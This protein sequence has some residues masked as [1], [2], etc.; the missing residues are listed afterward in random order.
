M[1]YAAIHPGW[2]TRSKV[3]LRRF[4][5]RSGFAGSHGSRET[6]GRWAVPEPRQ[7]TRPSRCG[8]CLADLPPGSGAARA[9]A[10]WAWD[11]DREEQARAAGRRN[12]ER[13]PVAPQLETDRVTVTL[14]DACHTTGTRA[15]AKSDGAGCSRRIAP[16]S[17]AHD[18]ALPPN[19]LLP[20]AALGRERLQRTFAGR[21]FAIL[22]EAPRTEA[23][24]EKV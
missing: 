7:D 14:Y 10:G 21:D 19:P 11:S 16:D 17:P 1:V 20:A 13:A 12:P 6:R 2:K 15:G 24:V 23:N 4:R 3:A 5:L 22:A 9:V 8:T 18:P